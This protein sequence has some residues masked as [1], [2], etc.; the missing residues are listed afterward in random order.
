MPSNFRNF[1]NSLAVAKDMSVSGDSRMM[2]STEV[3]SVCSTDPGHSRAGMLRVDSR[4]GNSR[5]FSET[6]ISESQ[7]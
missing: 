4:N 7:T 2:L 5:E 3:G 1:P 6:D